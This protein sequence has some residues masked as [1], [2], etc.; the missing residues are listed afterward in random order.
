MN[1]LQYGKELQKNG[2]IKNYAIAIRVVNLL[3]IKIKTFLL[4]LIKSSKN[5]TEYII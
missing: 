3:N 1:H 2:K 4:N 5:D